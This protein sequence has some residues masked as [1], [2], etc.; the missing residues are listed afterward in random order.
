M[1]LF[2]NENIPPLVQIGNTNAPLIEEVVSVINLA[3]ASTAG[4]DVFVAPPGQTWQVTGVQA[5]FG[6]TSTSGTLDV[7]KS[8]G[9][10]AVA[11]GTSVLTGTVSL[12]GTANTPVSGTVTANP[13]T[14]QLVGSAT[15]TS[16]D[17]LGIKLAG[18]LT[19]LVNC[20]VQIRLKRIA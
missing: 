8:T 18:T 2:S 9:T 4:Q 13:I 5:T 16:G 6:T 20:L 14:A 11:S 17:R 1:S 15:A 19:G 10:T 7:V 12:A 3:A